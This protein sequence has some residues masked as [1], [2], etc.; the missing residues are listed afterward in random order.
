MGRAIS[1]NE[2]YT[3]KFKELPFTGKWASHIGLPEPNKTWLVWGDSSNGKTSYACQ[4]VK[5]LAQFVRVYYNSMEE[6]KSKSMR[7]AFKLVGMEQTRHKVFLLDNES[8]DELDLRLSQRNLPRAVVID[9][10][11]Y[12]ELTFTRYK[13]LK[14][15]YPNVLWIYLSHEEGK[16]PDGKVAQKIRRDAM[17]KIRV[18]GFKAFPISRYGGGEVYII[19]EQKAA[20]H[21]PF[22]N[23]EKN[24]TQQK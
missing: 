14:E 5:Y 21:W 19:N 13:E 10:V 22:I 23:E 8:I 3:A 7:K 2:L 12:A 24:D 16:L 6:G 9:T 11:Q 1:V 4:L 17:V 20:E 15:K 18:V